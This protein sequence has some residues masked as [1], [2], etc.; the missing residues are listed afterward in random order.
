[1]GA[2]AIQGTAPLVSN[3]TA[4]TQYQIN[5][6]TDDCNNIATSTTYNYTVPIQPQIKFTNSFGAIAV[7][8]LSSATYNIRNG[9]TAN[10]YN[11]D[12]EIIVSVDNIGSNDVYCL[13]SEVF[14]SGSNKLNANFES[15]SYSEKTYY[16]E[17]DNSSNYEV[18]LTIRTRN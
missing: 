16:I 9:E 7:T 1:M 13:S 12:Q 3:S 6:S 14:T 18:S 8:T 4:M 5:N 15:G 11:S 2:D 17:G 10:L